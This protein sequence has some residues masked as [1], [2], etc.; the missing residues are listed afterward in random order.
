VVTVVMAVILHAL[1]GGG[2]RTVV[3]VASLVTAGVVT[4]VLFAR[5]PS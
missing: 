3:A 4:G 2:H 5:R 1:V